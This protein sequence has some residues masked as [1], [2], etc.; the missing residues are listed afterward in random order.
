[1]PEL[2]EIHNIAK[3]LNKELRGKS[4]TKVDVRQEK[5][6]NKPYKDFCQQIKRK[7]IRLVSSKGKWIKIRFEKD[8]YALMNLGMGADVLYHKH[9][10]EIPEKYVIKLK[11]N[12]NSLLTIRF[13]WFGHFHAVDKN[14]LHTHQAF[15][16]LGIDVC[17]KG[18]FTLD[19]F[20]ELLTNR[21]SAIKSFLL[22]QKNISGIGNVYIQDILFLAKLHP[23]RKI[24]EIA[25]NEK[26]KL[27]NVIK[28][29]L[30][31]AIN[32]RG[33]AYEKD[34]YNTPGQIKNFLIGYADG[35]PCPKCKAEI[36][37]IK[38][39]STS[40]YVCPTCQK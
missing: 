18:K 36:Q 23:K 26:K 38:T 30:A 14:E 37:K 2:P 16:S 10:K 40:S 13:W 4:V 22:N 8:I 35:K 25:L 12:D 17:D 1:M 9:Q 32:A 21:K 7:K 11:F 19:G 28:Q 31:K 34:I 6:L 20:L 5:C 29:N 33:L 39:G 15:S 24:S 27:F 3:Q